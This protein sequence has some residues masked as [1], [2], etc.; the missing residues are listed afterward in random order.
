MQKGQ[1]NFT[2]SF[3]LLFAFYAA[4]FAI[5]CVTAN[6]LIDASILSEKNFLNWDAMHYNTIHRDGYY[7]GMV[8]FFP[9]FPYIWK[10]TQLGSIGIGLLNGFIYMLSFAWLAA[11]FNIHSRR[12]LLLASTPVL[13]FMFLPFSEAVF[14]LTSTILLTGLKKNNYLLII[15]GIL[16]SGL[17]RPVATVFIPAFFILHWMIG[18]NSKKTMLQ[19]VGMVLVCAGSMFLVFLLQ[20]Y[21]TG[22]WF[23]FIHVQKDWGNYLRL[24]VFPLNSWAGGFIVRLD[25]MA[26]IFGIGAAVYLASLIIGRLRSAGDH[27]SLTPFLFSLCYV[28]ILTIVILFTRGGILNSHILNQKFFSRK[29]VIMVF[30]FSSIFWLLFASYVHI[31]TLLKFEFLSL[32]LFLLFISTA[33]NK[34]LKNTGYFSVLTFNVV[35]MIIFSQRFLTGEWVG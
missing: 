1:E 25:A 18:D 20:Y 31:Q 29:N 7:T 22:E 8:A 23:S 24:P 2:K 14:F 32:Y 16:L 9:L 10:L 33:E 30:F 12:L 11:V 13:I 19:S 21:Q 4:C 3:L 34:L 27:K 6:A 5:F 15:S 28:S 35:F 26:F 17:T